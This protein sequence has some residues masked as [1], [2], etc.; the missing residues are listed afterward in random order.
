[1]YL[2]GFMNEQF[3]DTQLTNLEEFLTIFTGSSFNFGQPIFVEYQSTAVFDESS[4]VVPTVEIL[5]QTL[6]TA[7]EGENL[8][9]YIGM[10]QALPPGNVFSTSIFVNQTDGGQMLVMASS[11]QK[12]ER[13]TT[14][15]G[16]AAGAAGLALL[17]AGFV[18]YKRQQ[19]KDVE[20]TFNKPAG[21]NVTVAGE[22]YAGTWSQA[23]ET[24]PFQSSL[25]QD[26]EDSTIHEMR[27]E[28]DDSI[29]NSVDGRTPINHNDVTRVAM[30]WEGALHSI[31]L[32]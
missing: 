12:R 17:A 21:D 1:M 19:G 14:A 7:F 8:N 31:S 28:D 10:L 26:R 29:D 6:E 25:G 4:T 27:D 24:Q 30:E 20:I 13:V 32:S 18:F 22:T 15:A 3:A 9:G 16:A 23:S 5:D 11:P 2:S